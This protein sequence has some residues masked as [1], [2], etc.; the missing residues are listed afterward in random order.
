MKTAL[1]ILVLAL[2]MFFFA[3]CASSRPK[4]A[5]AGGA[6][7]DPYDPQNSSKVHVLVTL[8]FEKDR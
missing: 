4:V 7:S 2:Y 1:L 3:G 8:T 5:L 6:D